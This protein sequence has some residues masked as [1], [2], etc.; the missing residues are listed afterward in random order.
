MTRDAASQIPAEVTPVT[1]KAKKPA[2][3]KKAPKKTKE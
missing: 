1:K 2:N 3:P